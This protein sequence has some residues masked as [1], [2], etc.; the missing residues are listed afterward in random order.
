M[1]GGGQAD[2]CQALD[3]R[4]E[5]LADAGEGLVEVGGDVGQLPLLGVRRQA[6]GDPRLM[7]LLQ[8]PAWPRLRPSDQCLTALIEFLPRNR[9]AG[10]RARLPV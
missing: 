8:G 7:R 6:E 4:A 3:Q 9:M 5:R 10:R 1:E 2:L